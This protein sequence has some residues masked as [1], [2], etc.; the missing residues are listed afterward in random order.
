MTNNNWVLKVLGNT[1]QIAKAYAAKCIE[2]EISGVRVHQDA[3]CPCVD[4]EFADEQNTICNR[5][6]KWQWENAKDD[7]GKLVIRDGKALNNWVPKESSPF[8]EGDE[9]E[10]SEAEVLAGKEG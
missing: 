6:D 7:E 8:Y 2:G 10:A 1:R 4:V 5:L 3:G 9:D